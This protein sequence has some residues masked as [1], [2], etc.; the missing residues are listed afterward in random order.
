MTVE[1]GLVFALVLVTVFSGALGFSGARS[2]T[3]SMAKALFY[4][5]LLATTVVLV[6]GVLG[7]AQII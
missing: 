7:V 3:A 6:V 4:L 2:R 1:L 5:V